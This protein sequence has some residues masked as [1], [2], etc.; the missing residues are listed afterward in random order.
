MALP[1]HFGQIKVNLARWLFEKTSGW[2]HGF[3]TL[4]V[5]H[6]IKK[7]VD[8]IEDDPAMRDNLRD[9]HFDITPKPP[10]A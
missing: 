7:A 2:P 8:I 10:E 3:R 5:G 6:S 9:G 1:K 4:F